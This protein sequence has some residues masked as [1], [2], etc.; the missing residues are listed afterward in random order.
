[1]TRKLFTRL[2]ISAHDLLIECGRYRQPKLLVENILCTSCK[3][4]DDEVHFVMNCTAHIGFIRPR[5]LML[6]KF[7]D[8]CPG[9]TNMDVY[10]KFICIMTPDNEILC[11][12]TEKF[13]INMVN[14][15][16]HL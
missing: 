2:R 16:G 8:E 10:D 1:M 12:I 3:V 11:K 13:L 14:I 15:R 6:Q 7:S 5:Q 9:F 4:I